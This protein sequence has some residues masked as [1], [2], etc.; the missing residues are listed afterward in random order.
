MEYLQKGAANFGIALSDEQVRQFSA[1]QS[2]LLDWNERVNLTAIT[3]PQDVQTR[4]FV[5]SLSCTLLTGDLNGQSLVD[6]GSGAG[7]PGLPLKILYPA[8]TLTLVDSVGK[9]TAFLE[10]VAK[11][12]GLTKVTV[13]LARA[14]ELGQ[15]AAHRERYDWAVARAVAH[16]S[17][18]MEYLLPLCRVGGHVLAQKGAKASLELIEAQEA[19]NVLGGGEVSVMSVLLEG[20]GEA[21][22][23]IVEKN[24][25]TPV[26]YPRRSGIPTKRPL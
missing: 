4:H 1:Y 7:L 26:T 10:L 17:P 24:R 6:I 9:K 8:M 13:L 21:N 12:L 14:E 5:D 22:L 19:I 3:T 18:L 15:D 2:L 20:Q 11:E 25:P 16:L 23:V